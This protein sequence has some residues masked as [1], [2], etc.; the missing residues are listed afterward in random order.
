MHFHSRR[1]HIETLA[2]F[3]GCGIVIDPMLSGITGALQGRYFP[4]SNPRY[5]QNKQHFIVLCGGP[6]ESDQH[7]ALALHELGHAATLQDWMWT[8]PTRRSA[9]VYA[10]F[11]AWEWAKGR[12]INWTGSMEVL[13]QSALS[14]YM[15]VYPCIMSF[16]GF[17]PPRQEEARWNPQPDA[18]RFE[19]QPWLPSRQPSGDSICLPRKQGS[20]VVV[21][22]V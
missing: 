6:E 14:T 7:Y 1:E 19:W 22:A 15:V 18:P 12:A 8:P 17:Y 20:I 4:C 9:V 5:P 13:K 16:P 10:E 11:L 2:R 3:L 21:S